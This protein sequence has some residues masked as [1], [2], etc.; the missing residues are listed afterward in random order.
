MQEYKSESKNF[1]NHNTL[2][3]IHISVITIKEYFLIGYY[4]LKSNEYMT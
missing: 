1:H 3:L 4:R 2:K